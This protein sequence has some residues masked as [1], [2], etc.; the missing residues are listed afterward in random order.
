MVL[1]DAL[2]QYDRLSELLVLLLRYFFMVINLSDPRCRLL[3][4]LHELVN[5]GL[6]SI[7]TVKVQEFLQKQVLGHRL[8]VFEQ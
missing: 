6:W 4:K 1:I 3:T 8:K 5:V 2:P 7:A